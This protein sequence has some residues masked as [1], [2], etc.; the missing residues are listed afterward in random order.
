MAK[1]EPDARGFGC[2]D[3]VLSCVLYEQYQT[4]NYTRERYKM[5]HLGCRHEAVLARYK[6]EKAV[7]GKPAVSILIARRRGALCGLEADLHQLPKEKQK[8]EYVPGVPLPEH[9][10]KKRR[11]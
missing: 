7:D 5:V 10:R 3:C 9:V 6:N 11:R 4:A 1:F 8:I 2:R